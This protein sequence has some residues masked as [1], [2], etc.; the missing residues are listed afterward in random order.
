MA[1]EM[2]KKCNHTV[3]TLYI[4]IEERFARLR[5]LQAES[6]KHFTGLQAETDKRY[7]ERFDSQKREL[8]SALEAANKATMKEEANSEKWRMNANE[9]RGAMND[10]EKELM[11]RTLAEQQNTNVT[12][13]L[14]SLAVRM[15]RNEAR[16]A[17]MH[18]SW[19]IMVAVIGILIGI[20]TAAAAIAMLWK[21]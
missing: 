13:E 2:P 10:R 14:A 7:T 20:A 11:P 19:L 4:L 15:E 8:A 17:G 18:S 9:W 6:D 21:H 16:G 12:K 1:D 5:E 3:E